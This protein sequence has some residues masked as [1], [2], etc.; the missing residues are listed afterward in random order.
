MT[1]V[2]K[3]AGVCKGL[4][5]YHFRSKEHLLLEAQ[6]AAYRKIHE[7]FQ[8]RLAE[9]DRGIET[10]LEGLDAIWKAVFEMRTWAPFMMETVSLASQNEIVR[11]QVMGFLD[12]SMP[13]LES[14][15]KE[16]FRDEQNKLIAPP[17]RIARVV[18]AGIHGLIVELSLAKTD[19]DLRDISQIFEDMMHMF[20]HSVL[21]ERRRRAKERAYENQDHRR[22]WC[23]RHGGAQ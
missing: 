1:A 5:H 6:Q 22:Q 14:G 2:A 16:V 11:E 21:S 17:T 4:L 12:E 19:A 13:L 15:I 20:T 18:R 10:A 8:G 7:Q 23:L 3:A 9:G